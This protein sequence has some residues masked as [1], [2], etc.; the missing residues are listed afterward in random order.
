MN[1]IDLTKSITSLINGLYYLY[2]YTKYQYLIDF[3]EK[4]L[5]KEY[6]Y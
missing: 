6:V 5:Q 3:I 2:S 4:I 1:C